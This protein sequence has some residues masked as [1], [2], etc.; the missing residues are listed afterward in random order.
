MMLT[1]GNAKENSKPA[2]TALE[3]CSK[4]VRLTGRKLKK[5]DI[6]CE[7][8][9]VTKKVTVKQKHWQVSM[10]AYASI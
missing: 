6:M 5:I 9:N 4:S 2:I 1:D 7:H 10:L 8:V 3:L